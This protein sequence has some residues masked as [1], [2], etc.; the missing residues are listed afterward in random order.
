MGRI[1]KAIAG[2]GAV[3][4]T[5]IVLAGAVLAEPA[6]T[7]KTEKDDW[8]SPGDGRLFQAYTAY[9]NPTGMVGILNTGGAIE[10]KGHPFFEPIGANGRACVTCHQ[11]ADGMTIS[12]ATV[13]K[14]W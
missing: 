1:A 3:T 9:A 14:R 8:W 5:A 10:T 4:L 7:E 2:L 11:P 6:K 12:V 13:Q